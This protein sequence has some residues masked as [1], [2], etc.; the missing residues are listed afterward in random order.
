MAITDNISEVSSSATGRPV[1]T[2]LAAPG[3]AFGNRVSIN[4]AGNTNWATSTAIHFTMYETQTIGSTVVKDSTT[5]TDWKGTLAST[6]ISNLEL[7]GGTDRAYA[8]GI[9]V[10]ITPT[11][12]WARD[13]YLWGTE[14]HDVLG[15]HTV[16]TATSVAATGAITAATVATTGAISTNTISEKTATSGVTIDGVTLKDGIVQPRESTTASTASLTPNADTYD[17]YTVTALAAA[18]TVNEP[19]GTPV[20][21]QRLIFRLLDDGTARAITWNA[22]YR[23]VGVDLPTTTVIS[24][25]VYIGAL[26]NS[27]DSK[28]DVI[29]VNEE[30]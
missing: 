22:A 5:Q 18:I 6:T 1:V 30:E 29:V 11:A 17:F 4:I 2:T 7:T 27:A 8:A 10:E 16:V 28:W 20:N 23:A 24:K 19:S 13:L 9:I 25:T 14:E 15:K 21:G 26:Y 3:H 12:G